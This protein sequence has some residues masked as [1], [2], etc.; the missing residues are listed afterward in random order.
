MAALLAATVEP[1]EGVRITQRPQ[2]NT[3]FAVV[4]RQAADAVRA[5]YPFYDW[6]RT[7]GEVRWM[8]SWDTTAEDVTGFAQALQEALA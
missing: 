3:V 6:D 4:D 7:T 5:R 8:T 1:V 2:A